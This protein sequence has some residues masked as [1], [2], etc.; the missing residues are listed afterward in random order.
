MREKR[1]GL[2]VSVGRLW[3]MSLPFRLVCHSR[4]PGFAPGMRNLLAYEFRRLWHWLY[5]RERIDYRLGGLCTI[6][7]WV[8]YRR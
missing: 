4:A 7:K 6:L 2:V 1:I 5:E 8:G 3:V